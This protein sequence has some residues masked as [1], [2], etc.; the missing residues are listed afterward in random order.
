M[1]QAPMVLRY[2]LRKSPAFWGGSCVEVG[3]IF[4]GRFGPPE[5][6]RV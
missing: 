6:V 4:G 1:L 2:D 3:V 5:M